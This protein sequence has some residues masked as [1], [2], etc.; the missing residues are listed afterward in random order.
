MPKESRERQVRTRYDETKFRNLLEICLDVHMYT[1]GSSD[2]LSPDEYEYDKQT[3]AIAL[4][5]WREEIPRSKAFDDAVKAL[6]QATLNEAQMTT[7]QEDGKIRECC[8]KEREA[9]AQICDAIE[10]HYREDAQLFEQ[11][12]GLNTYS[13]DSAQRCAFAIRTRMQ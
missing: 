5:N 4:N 8:K 2:D 12:S 7:T 6:I 11:T 9:N 1:T 10:Q 13:A 3:L